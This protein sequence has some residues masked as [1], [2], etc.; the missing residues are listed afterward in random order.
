MQQIIFELFNIYKWVEYLLIVEAGVGFGIFLRDKFTKPYFN[1]SN[2]HFG[3]LGQPVLG[4]FAS[5]L[6]QIM[7]IDLIQAGGWAAGLTTIGN[8]VPK[9]LDWMAVKKE[10]QLKSRDVRLARCI[11]KMLGRSEEEITKILQEAGM[12]KNDAE[13]TEELQIEDASRALEA[14]KKVQEE[15]DLPCAFEDPLCEE[16]IEESVIEQEQIV[17][18]T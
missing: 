7:G 18:E 1:D 8:A 16:P 13:K 11:A 5:I 12:L 6:F 17:T 3:T 4:F 2:F 9:M 15:K 10:T 14:L